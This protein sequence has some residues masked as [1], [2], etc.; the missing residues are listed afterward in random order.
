[1]I[2][3]FETNKAKVCIVCRNT[4]SNDQRTLTEAKV[5]AEAG[6]QVVVIGLQG[7]GQASEEEHDGF[8]I[9]RVSPTIGLTTAFRDHFYLPIY[10]RLPSSRKYKAQSVYKVVSRALKWL[11]Q[12]L[13]RLTTYKRLSKAMLSEQANYLHAHFP[14]SLIALTCM[15]SALSRRRYVRDFNDILVLEDPKT[16]EGG[17][18]NQK[19]LWD[20]PPDDREEKRIQATICSIPSEVQSIL[21]VGCGDGR[22]TN[23]LANLYPLVMGI[24]VSKEALQYVQAETVHGSVEHLPFKDKSFDLVLAT[25]LL[26]HLPERIYQRSLREIKRVARRWILVGVPWKEQ[27]SIA[28]ARCPRCNNVFHVNYHFRSFDESKLQALFKPYFKLIKLEMTGGERRWFAP[29]LLWIKQH[30][31][32]IWM[33]TPTTVCPNCNVYLY[34]GG[35][36]ESN[37]ISRLCDR[38]NEKIKPRKM[39]GKSHVI[40]LYQR[41][42]NSCP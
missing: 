26:E 40:A 31:G 39:L 12:R 1:M 6:L 32:G 24:D 16:V 11:D 7:K 14:I 42:T 15:I 34:P 22:I 27:L 8:R 3:S 36:P 28:Q 10:R 21:D 41:A 23:R 33:R 29:S 38:L 20:K 2:N 30:L 37:A 13:K 25:E 19:I 17:Y 9:R 4:I 35:L 5:L 18:Y